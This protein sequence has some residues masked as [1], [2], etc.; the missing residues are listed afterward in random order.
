LAKDRENPADPL[1]A[2]ITLATFQC[3]LGRLAHAL[4]VQ[5]WRSATPWGYAA[6]GRKARL[7]ESPR[8][9]PES[10]PKPP[11]HCERQIGFTA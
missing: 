5:T 11:F 10:A 6:N 9:G 8:E 7:R 3:G 4:A 1:A 2:S